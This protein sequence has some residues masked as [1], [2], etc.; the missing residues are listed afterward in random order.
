LSGTLHVTIA[1][2]SRKLP[3]NAALAAVCTTLL[4][5][6]TPPLTAQVSLSTIVDQ[7]QRNSSAVK[8][9]Q[10]DLAKAN[11]AFA[12]TQDVYVPNLVF[13]S[14]IGPPS[15]GFPVGQP[16]VANATMQSLVF[17]YAQR[18][19]IQAARSGVA[20]ATLNLKETAEQVALDAATDYMELDTVNREIDKTRQQS[21]LADHLVEIEA[22]RTAAGVDATSELLQAKLTSAQIRLKLLHLQT[23]ARTLTSQLA[24]LT[25][26]P[27][28]TILTDHASI[29]AIPQIRGQDSPISTM[30]IQSAQAQARSKQLQALGDELNTKIRPLIAFGAQYN[31]DATSLNNYNLYYGGGN[32]KFKFKADNFS[33]GISIQIPIFDVGRRDKA[34]ESAAD[35]L[36]A[37]VEAEQAQQQNDVQIATLTGN[38][39]ELD[40]TAE[41]ASLKQQIAGEQVKTIQAQLQLGNGQG[42]EAGSQPQLSPKAEQMARIDES[43]KMIDALDSG[44]DLSKARLSLLRALGHMEDW[45]DQVHPQ[46]PVLTPK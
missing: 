19:Y 9:A 41:I 30:A 12:Q 22:Q 2:N 5:F 3:T 6:L 38:I 45:L 35:A 1:E 27:G 32:T 26:L 21:S 39:R 13:G 16:S 14:S 7:A 28:S 11:A 43:Q 4:I 17:S 42:V 25:G 29:P 46:A 15:I 34:R 31:R 33:A 24:T 20:A 23:R 8:L 36:R 10:A 37:T 44:F 18:Q 40:A